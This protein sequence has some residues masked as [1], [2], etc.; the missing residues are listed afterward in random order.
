MT[1]EFAFEEEVHLIVGHGITHFI[2][3]PWGRRMQRALIS[4]SSGCLH[5][6]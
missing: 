1:E 2:G 3:P 5:S 4:Q 6:F